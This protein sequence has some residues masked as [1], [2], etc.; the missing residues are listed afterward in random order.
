MTSIAV[1]DPGTTTGYVLAEFTPDTFPEILDKREVPG[2]LEGADALASQVGIGGID[3]IVC[4]RFRM[5]PRARTDIQVEPKRIEGAIY[6]WCKPVVWQY[7]EA[8]LLAG[9][10]HGSPSRNKTAADN[11]LRG[12]GLWTLPSEV[13]NHQDAN[14]INAAMKH[15]IA[16]L[17]NIGHQP[18]LDALHG[19]R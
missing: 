13:D 6:A 4:E 19:M 9:A 10:G 16:Y 8:M 7:P 1:F 3:V 2:A 12:L 18:T 17:R 14:D 5:T 15:L 11:V